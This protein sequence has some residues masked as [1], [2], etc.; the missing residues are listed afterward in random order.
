MYE[1]QLGYEMSI[2]L[3]EMLEIAARVRSHHR[4]G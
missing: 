4:K 3:L 2:A 1:V